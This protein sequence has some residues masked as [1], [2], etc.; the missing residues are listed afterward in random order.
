LSKMFVKQPH[1]EK[2][3][4][5]T[6]TIPCSAALLLALAAPTLGHAQSVDPATLFNQANQMNN[7]EQDMAKELKSKAG[8]NQALITMADTIQEDHKANQAA[9][10][11]LAS[12]KKVTLKSYEKNKA[13]QDQLDNLKGAQFNQSFLKM[14][15]RDH[16]K[17]LASFRRARRE[18]SGD[19]D[20]LVYIDETIPVLEAHLKMAQNLHRDD[21]MLGSKENAATNKD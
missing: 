16:E 13:A 7:E 9:L 17:A 1:Q 4:M 19:P 6:I 2:K 12:Q 3:L 14:D 11:A 8:D 21:K 18:F 15:I 5:K 20:V 10:E